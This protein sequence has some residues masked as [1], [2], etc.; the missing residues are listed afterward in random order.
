MLISFIV[1]VYNT[2]KYLQKCI[3]SIYEQG[4][5]YKD[6]EVIA[7][8]DGSTDNS[9]KLLRELS[10]RYT[11][12]II[13]DQINQGL[14]AV[15]NKGVLM[16]KGQYIQFIDSDDYILPNQLQLILTK[17]CIEKELDLLQFNFKKIIND[18]EFINEELVVNIP[19]IMSGINYLERN[20]IFTSACLFIIRRDFFIT[21]NL[22]FEE[23]VVCE[24]ID[25]TYKAIYSSNT[26]KYSNIVYYA[27]NDNPTSICHKPKDLFIRDL[28]HAS[29]RLYSFFSKK[30]VFRNNSK[31]RNKIML[32]VKK[33]LFMAYNYFL[34]YR[35]Y[36]LI[37]L[38]V[39]ETRGFIKIIMKDGI[40]TNKKEFLILNLWVY[41]PY[42]YS[43]ILELRSL[44]FQYKNNIQ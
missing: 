31:F 12:L 23:G 1:P 27:N 14:S 30:N 6:F 35:T 4:L 3:E 11:N 24:G 18:E 15:R 44:F 10:Q 22:F 8:N 20:N 26:I 40:R 34:Y 19:E 39:K 38:N 33:F 2:D 29:F 16:A 32:D 28:V 5:S 7:I 9:L 42:I 25:W 43:I 37:N 21:N 36:H 17:E 13:V 41:M